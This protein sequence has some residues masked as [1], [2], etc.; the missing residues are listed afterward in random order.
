MPKVKFCITDLYYVFL[1]VEGSCS[2]IVPSEVCTLR[3]FE[4]HNFLYQM[5]ANNR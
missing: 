1:V 5:F 4:I 3:M 2:F